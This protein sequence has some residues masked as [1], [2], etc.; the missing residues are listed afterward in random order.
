MDQKEGR[1]EDQRPPTCACKTPPSRLTRTTL[2]GI[3]PTT[4]GTPT[5]QQFQTARIGWG[6]R[7]VFFGTLQRR[8]VEAVQ[9]FSHHKQGVEGIRVERQHL[10]QFGRAEH[11]LISVRIH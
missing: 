8:F 5:D 6:A 1:L 11:Q 10:I 4:P 9:T 7:L 2:A 3:Q